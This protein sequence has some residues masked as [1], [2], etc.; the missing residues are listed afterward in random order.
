M[1]FTVAGAGL[2]GGRASREALLWDKVDERLSEKFDSDSGSESEGEV[3]PSAA[4]RVSFAPAPSRRGTTFL[5]KS[6][7]PREEGR[8]GG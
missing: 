6:S 7:G 1:S 3:E 2:D 5:G 8:T 4:P